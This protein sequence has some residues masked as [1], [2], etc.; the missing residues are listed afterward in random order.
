MKKFRVWDSAC[1][2][3]F[4]EHEVLLY[5][6]GSMVYRDGGYINDGQVCD[7]IEKD[8][9]EGNKIYADS[10][11]VEFDRMSM[12]NPELEEGVIAY[13]AYD[14]NRCCYDLCFGLEKDAPRISISDFTPFLRSEFKIIDTIQENKLGLIK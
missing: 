10:S 5:G 12:N 13:I 3:F 6:N 9:I 1:N 14:N 7:Y 2:C 8:D 11:I 4:K